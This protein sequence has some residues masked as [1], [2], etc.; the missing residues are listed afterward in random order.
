MIHYTRTE[1]V[2]YREVFININKDLCFEGSR[3]EESWS[4]H[5][6]QVVSVHLAAGGGGG[7]EREKLEQVLGHNAV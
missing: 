2:L 1:S 5:E 4:K 3:E 6:C 7:H